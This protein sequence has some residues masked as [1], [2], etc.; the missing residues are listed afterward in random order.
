MP[1]IFAPINGIRNSAVCT[2]RI[3]G[4]NVFDV[5]KLIP[6]LKNIPHRT[7]RL[8]KIY[9][10]NA[11]LLDEA[12]ALY[13]KAPHSFTGDDILEISLHG[14]GFIISKFL[15]ILGKIDGFSF[16]KPGEF[17][18][19]AVQNQKI[20]LSKAEAINKLI[21]GESAVQH[22]F[23]MAEFNG[24]C[25]DYY[26]EIK[27]G[28]I[29]ALSLLE[30][31]IDFAEEEAIST[32]FIEKIRNIINTV[33]AVM[34]KNLLYSSSKEDFDVSIAIIGKPN[35]GKSS[36]FNCISNTD[37]AIVSDIPGT[38]R[39]AIRKNVMIS[40]F[41]V[42]IIDTA[43]IRN[44]TDKIEQIG[45][46]KA[47]TVA[48][49]ADIILY[50][51]DS[52]DEENIKTGEYEGEIIKVWAKSDLNPPPDGMVSV[53]VKNRDIKQ[54]ETAITKILEERL[55][56]M[57]S[58]GFLCNERQKTVLKSTIDILTAIDFSL[59]AEIISE[60]IR[61]AISNIS[62]LVGSVDTEEILGEIFSNFC[63]GK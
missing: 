62:H 20:S 4:S 41:K 55:Q 37:D 19:R 24:A 57:E 1:S 50:L 10:E 44:T 32:D 43:G 48:K 40:G 54:L 31:Y 15:S 18:L 30:T 51:Q 17:C 23:A 14:S 26:I 49:N 56:Q 21:S 36:L 12:I 8:V 5:T 38:T 25:H 58:V 7:A 27:S 59:P 9:D 33:V 35:V 60:Q 6:N 61:L 53:S 39:D 34:R 52:T 22:R 28:L 2:V 42:Q 29:K 13:F 46:Q 45:M 3:S 63:I 11:A 47:F 16:A